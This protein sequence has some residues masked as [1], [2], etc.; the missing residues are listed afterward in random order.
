[1]SSFTKYKTRLE[2]RLFKFGAKLFWNP[3][4]LAFKNL[5]YKFALQMIPRARAN[6][7]II[8]P[9]FS[10]SQPSS[11]LVP[12]ISEKQEQN[13]T[14]KLVKRVHEVNTRGRT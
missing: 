3:V 6:V 2:M 1:M 5:R 14:I 12:F 4:L 8:H 13:S 9:K 10:L 11:V 7:I